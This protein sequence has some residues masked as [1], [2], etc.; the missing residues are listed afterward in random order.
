MWMHLLESLE[1]SALG[2]WIAAS[3][4][5]WA[6][7]TIL[8]MHT[9]GMGLLVGASAVVDLRLLGFARRVPL[10][11]LRKVSRPV[12]IGFTVNATTGTL[13]FVA[14]ATEKGT[15]KIFALKL[16]LIL[17]ALLADRRIRRV[18]FRN[19]AALDRQIPIGTR[20]LA[21]TSL[22]FW[23]GAITAGRLMAYIN[24]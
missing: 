4:S 5:L 18:V 10:T 12:W 14:A 21:A 1:N 6:Y 22:F 20:A 2:M 23:A 17:I 11:V 8:T 16:T 15:Q 3:D 19:A 13:L 24:W 7:P 9:F